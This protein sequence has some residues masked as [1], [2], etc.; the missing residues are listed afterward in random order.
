VLAQA[1]GA[2]SC[3]IHLRGHSGLNVRFALL[4]RDY[5]TACP[6]AAQACGRFEVRL[7]R[8]V[9]DLAGY[10]QIKAPAQEILLRAAES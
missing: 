6:E 10:G 1:P 9:T 3:N 8:S 7:A 4:F 2:R 5:L